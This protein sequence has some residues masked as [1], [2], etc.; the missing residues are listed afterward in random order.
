VGGRLTAPATPTTTGKIERF[1]QT[2]RRELLNDHSHFGSLQTAQ[3]A[4]DVWVTEYNSDRPHQAL[5]GHAPVTPADRFTPQ[6]DAR[7]ELIDLW[8]PPAVIP[9]GSAESSPPPEGTAA[10]LGR[11]PGGP[12]E[13]DRWCRH[14]R[15]RGWPDGSSGSAPPGPGR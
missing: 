1:H 10:A 6:P 14:Q 15:T 12:V 3:D 4:I 2:L 7:R 13:F 8:L 5:N 9:A 11:W